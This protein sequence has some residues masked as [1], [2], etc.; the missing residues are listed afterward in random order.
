MLSPQVFT[1]L[2][3]ILL[4]FLLGPLIAQAAAPTGYQF[5]QPPLAGIG[6]AINLTDQSGQR[7]TLDR[8]QGKTALL[9][10]G[11]SRCSTVC[12][13]AMSQA[14]PLLDSFVARPA[15]VVI[16]VTLDPLNDSPARLSDF[17][18]GI[19]SRVVGLTGKPEQIEE[20]AERYGVAVRPQQGVGPDHSGKWY[21]ID[22]A[23]RVARVYDSSTPAAQLGAD[24][25]W[26]Q[27]SARVQP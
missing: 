26:A 3:A 15:P 20:V 1:R 13:V 10:F 9:F 18:A 19:D 17:L 12:P 8:I 11:F 24:V 25:R 2:I 23:G 16:F 27:N 4:A 6:G 22:A 14:R 5:G 7:F 21:L